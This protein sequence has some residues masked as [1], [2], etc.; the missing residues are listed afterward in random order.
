MT[1]D[2]IIN[3]RGGK[4]CCGSAMQRKDA[5][6]QRDSSARR[7]AALCIPMHECG[8][9]LNQEAAGGETH[10][11]RPAHPP[12]TLSLPENFVSCIAVH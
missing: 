8:V 1:L 9:S 7:A 4:R 12:P 3:A 2:V 6:E 5:G 10:H 11:P